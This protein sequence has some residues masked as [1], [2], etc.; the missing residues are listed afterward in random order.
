MKKLRN[1]INTVVR[2][3]LIKDINISNPE[4]YIKLIK[5]ANPKYVEVK[6]YSHVGFSRKRLKD[7]HS[8]FH[9]V[10]KDFAKQLTKLSDYKITNEKKESK[11]VLLKN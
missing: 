7:F 10:V 3:T 4:K 1:K 8:P 9:E 5:L 11:I 2:M 6:A